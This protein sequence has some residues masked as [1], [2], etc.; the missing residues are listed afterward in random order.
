MVYKSS[1]TLP[2]IELNDISGVLMDVLLK[3]MSFKF[4][5]IL[6][7]MNQL[8]LAQCVSIDKTQKSANNKSQNK[9]LIYQFYLIKIGLGKPR[10]QVVVHEENKV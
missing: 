10:N 9:K 4:S 7:R 6:L 2:N 5:T 8:G 3:S 1:L